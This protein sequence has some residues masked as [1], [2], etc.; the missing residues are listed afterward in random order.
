MKIGLSLS[1]KQKLYT[2]GVVCIIGALSLAG[3]AIRFSGKVGEAAH[4]IKEQ[5]FAPL[6]DVQE[7]NTQLKEVR[8]RMAGVLVD[9]MPYPGSR[10]H[11]KETMKNA[12]VL[13]KGFKSGVGEID[14]DSGKLIAEIDR[15][16]PKLESFAQKLE[17]AYA[18]EDRKAL[19]ALLED[20]WPT[21]QM[22]IVKQLDALLPI[23]SERA[24]QEAS[25]LKARALLFRNV[26]AAVALVVV[27][28][29]LIITVLIIRSLMG[30][31]REAI[32]AA[33]ALARGDLAR[34]VEVR[35]TDEMG[36]LLRALG[37]TVSQLRGIVV[38]VRGATEAITAGTGEI[39][40]G[41]ADL[42]QRTEEQ[43][44]SLEETASSMEELTGTV[45]QNADNARQ[46]N[47]LAASASEVAVRG[48]DVVNEVV[49]TMSAIN[50]SS[51]K[52]VD[53]ISVIDGIAFQTNIL[54]LNA[55]VEAARAGEQG[56]GFA[57]VASEVRSL[58]Q[59]SAAA[60]KEI[61]A[62]IGDSVGKVEIGTKLVDQAGT[63]MQEIVASVKRVT[64]IMAEI[65]A[66]SQEQS[67]GIEQVNQ[68]ITQM[69][70][71]TQQN[72]ALVEEASAAAQSMNEQAQKLS[73]AVAVFKLD[74]GSA[75]DRG[76]HAAETAQAPVERM[77]E[78]RE[79]NRPTNVAR[80]R[81][82]PQPP[83]S[84]MRNTAVAEVAIKPAPRKAVNGKAGES[85][86]EEF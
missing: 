55:A 56:R 77:L 62:L 85:E 7:L 40:S 46:A 83:D 31:L 25:G 32:A 48:G 49:G 37:N 39:A 53:I 36:Q 15:D 72:S 70:A 43:A 54:A 50:D 65:T 26:A 20:E 24:A 13:W 69:D 34:N 52:I 14:G 76:A 28:A 1:I 3:A 12:P 35:T 67:S 38:G 30:G 61:K 29:S 66:A 78:R 47:Q 82:K 64:D 79:P 18:A 11:L 8:F 63:T 57:V 41:N 21:I 42:S 73:E 60:A 5:R 9:Q 80:L 2:L 4:V 6:S 23:L 84:A 68:A 16:M 58:A 17:K 86:W 75:A 59:R 74:E 51:K 22:K 44:S 33:E 27:L 81:A 71:M 19:E 10:I 45:K